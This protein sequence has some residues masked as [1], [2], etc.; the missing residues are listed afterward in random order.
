[1]LIPLEVDLSGQWGTLW[2]AVKSAIPSISTILGM[3]ALILVVVAIAA[4]IWGKRRNVKA[5]DNQAVIGALIVAAVFA[6][7]DLVFPL[8]LTIADGLINFVIGIAQ[9]AVK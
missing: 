2:G 6:A 5:G 9:G 1:M 3:I 4:W 7:P 8:L